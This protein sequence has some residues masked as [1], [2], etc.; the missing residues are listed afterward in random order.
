MSNTP[1]GSVLIWFPDRSRYLDTRRAR[2]QRSLPTRTCP[3]CA[4]HAHAY[5]RVWVCMYARV[6]VQ[7]MRLHTSHTR[8]SARTH[9]RSRLS[10]GIQKRVQMYSHTCTPHACTCTRMYT[11][12]TQRHTRMCVHALFARTS[13]YIQASHTIHLP[14]CAILIWIIYICTPTYMTHTYMYIQ[15]YMRVCMY[16]CM[17]VYM[18]MLYN[19]I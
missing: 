11:Q 8:T 2:S 17:Y 16:V 10:A 6:F 14:I 4:S 15:I 18:C 9:R 3:L 5:V 1:Q 12:T 13:T 19:H 7:S